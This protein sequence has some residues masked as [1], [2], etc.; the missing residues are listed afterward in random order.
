MSIASSGTPPITSRRRP[1]AKAPISKAA[2]STASLR[3]APTSRVRPITIS[4]AAMGA[5]SMSCPSAISQPSAQ[6][7]ADGPVPPDERLEE[8]LRGHR[9]R[10]QR[11]PDDNAGRPERPRP[12]AAMHP[13]RGPKGTP[14]AKSSAT[15][16]RLASGRCADM[17]A[18]RCAWH[19]R[20]RARPLRRCAATVPPIATPV[21]DAPRPAVNGG[22]AIDQFQARAGCMVPRRRRSKPPKPPRPASINAQLAGSGTAATL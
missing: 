13:Q 4:D 10:G 19:P 17:K 1:L 5:A 6:H 16:G 7:V 11:G 14:Y 12:G 3:H 20:Q 15:S 8:K 22:A 21:R 18:V 2:P 9:K